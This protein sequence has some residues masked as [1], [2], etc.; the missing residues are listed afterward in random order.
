[1]SYHL[2]PNL[3][4]DGFSDRS[5]DASPHRGGLTGRKGYNAP[6]PSHEITPPPSRQSTSPLPSHRE[7]L[8]GRK[9]YNSPPPTQSSSDERSHSHSPATGPSFHDGLTGRKG[10]NAEH[11]S[12]DARSD[13][14]SRSSS[15]ATYVPQ[16]REGSLSDRKG[17][18]ATPLQSRE[19]SPAPGPAPHPSSLS[20]SR[21]P[22]AYLAS[23]E[24]RSS[25]SGALSGRK[26]YNGS[27][28]L[29]PSDSQHH[30]GIRGRKGYNTEH[31][32]ILSAGLGN[33]PEERK[34]GH[35]E[36]TH[37]GP[38]FGLGI[39]EGALS[40]RKGY[41]VPHDSGRSRSVSPL[42]LR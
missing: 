1:M 5:R 39:R 27:P 31:E 25:T 20:P 22:S 6:L 15:P 14:R 36:H 16:R 21:N 9:G 40:G 32:R 41:N 17:Y 13:S 10:Y 18:N 4:A 35:A 42:P 24:R 34:K 19:V 30:G 37:A 3:S 2:S 26:G 38:V 28:H 7:G 8:F 23:Y 29:M 12:I 33:E 11:P